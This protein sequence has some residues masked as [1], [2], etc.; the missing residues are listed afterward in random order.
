MSSLIKPANGIMYQPIEVVSILAPYPDNSKSRSLLI[1]HFLTEKL[2]PV[3][4]AGIYRL[5]Q[6]NAAGKLIR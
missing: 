6:N 1:S 4:R 2:V 3:K 5:L